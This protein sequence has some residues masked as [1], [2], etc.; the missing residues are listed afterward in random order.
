MWRPFYGASGTTGLD[1]TGCPD[2]PFIKVAAIRK[3]GT[4]ASRHSVIHTV[5]PKH[6]IFLI[7]DLESRPYGYHLKLSGR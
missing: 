6:P 7:T 4:F 3:F 2:N 5:L 1:D